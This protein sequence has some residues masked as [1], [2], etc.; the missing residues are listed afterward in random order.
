MTALQI[1]CIK[2]INLVYEFSLQRSISIRSFFTQLEKSIT[3]LIKDPRKN[4]QS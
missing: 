2:I 1:S 3:T 4:S